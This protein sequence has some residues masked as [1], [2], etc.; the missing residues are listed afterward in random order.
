WDFTMNRAAQESLSLKDDPVRKQNNE[1]LDEIVAALSSF[2]LDNT[3]VLRVTLIG[4]NEGAASLHRS[5][6]QS[7]YELAQARAMAV[8]LVLEQL[9]ARSG[10]RSGRTFGNIEWLIVPLS[11]SSEGTEESRRAVEVFVVPVRQNSSRGLLKERSDEEIRLLPLIEYVYFAMYTITT[12][13]YGDIKPATSYSMFVCTLAN[14][15][16][17]FFLVIFF[18][19]L[20]SPKRRSLRKAGSASDTRRESNK[21]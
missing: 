18:N 4:R 10:E 15:Y 13:G 17:V 5:G 16:A 1:S 2:S 7:N 12:T 20:L 3:Q 9:I 6:Y 11:E 14:F 8:R 19:V 21:H